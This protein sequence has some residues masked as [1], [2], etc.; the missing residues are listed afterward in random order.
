MLLYFTRLVLPPTLYKPK[1]DFVGMWKIYSICLTEER[2]S[3]TTLAD[4]TALNEADR[5]AAFS[6][7]VTILQK[8]HTGE[9]L[10][11]L[12]NT[13]CHEAHTF[14][15]DGNKEKIWRIWGT[16]TIRVYFIYLN[17]KTILILKTLAKRKDKLD[18]GEIAILEDNTSKIYRCLEKNEFI[19]RVI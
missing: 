6:S 19:T 13:K 9:K 17:D 7:F 14:K 5:G 12:F 15:F 11:I 1:P 3:S 4:I 16:G 18:A 10:S 8:T 2:T